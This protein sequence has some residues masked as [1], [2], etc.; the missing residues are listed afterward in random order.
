MPLLRRQGIPVGQVAETRS[1]ADG[2]FELGL[3]L[4]TEKLYE[5]RLLSP[6]HADLRVG[7]EVVFV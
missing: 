5:I 1:L 2:A 7:V 6:Q 4:A 3:H